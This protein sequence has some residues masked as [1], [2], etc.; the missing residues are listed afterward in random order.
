[1][2]LLAERAVTVITCVALPV[3][4]RSGSGCP[5]GAGWITAGRLPG[6]GG[7]WCAGAAARLVGGAV[8]C[9]ALDDKEC[10]VLRGV[11]RV[12]TAVLGAGPAGVGESAT[13]VIGNTTGRSTG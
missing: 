12:A 2:V 5:P 7:A 13:R 9:A 1:V 8:R 11:E 10:G 3:P 4:I 6:R